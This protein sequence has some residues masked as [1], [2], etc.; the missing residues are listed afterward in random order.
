M[1]RGYKG[2]IDGVLVIKVSG[3]P[4][5]MYYGY[6][7]AEAER[8]YRAAHGLKGKRISWTLTTPW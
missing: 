6:P 3:G 8:N 2:Y 7:A 5:R 1:L 4:R